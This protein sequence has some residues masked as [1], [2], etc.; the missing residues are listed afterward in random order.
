MDESVD[1]D[2]DR[3]ELGARIAGHGLE[4]FRNIEARHVNLGYIPEPDAPRL[5]RDTG[6]CGA[7]DDGV[8]GERGLVEEVVPRHA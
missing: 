8:V 3:A 2:E 1:V 7:V 5:Q 6:A 4:A